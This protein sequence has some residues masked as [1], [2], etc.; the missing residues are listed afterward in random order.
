[1]SPESDQRVGCLRVETPVKVRGSAQG[2]VKG[3]PR[4]LTPGEWNLR[5]PVPCP[6]HT[7]GP[8]HGT[9]PREVVSAEL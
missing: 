4:E 8:M 3:H 1:M 5:R 7:R 6:L 2:V 9:N